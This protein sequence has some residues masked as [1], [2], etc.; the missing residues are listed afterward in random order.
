MPTMQYGRVAHLCLLHTCSSGIAFTGDRWTI[1]IGE[2]CLPIRVIIPI[3]CWHW[4]GSR[5]TET[6]CRN[7]CID[8]VHLNRID[9]HRTQHTTASLV[10]LAL[11]SSCMDLSADINGC[12][13][14]L[15][16]RLLVARVWLT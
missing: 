16:T 12:R 7:L 2:R 15:G 13:R 14:G 8:S 10:Q 11:A 9:K 3:V 4:L 6:I 1:E 5:S